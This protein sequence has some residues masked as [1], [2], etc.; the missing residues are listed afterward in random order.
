MNLQLI[1]NQGLDKLRRGLRPLVWGQSL[2]LLTGVGL[3]T[4][5]VTFWVSH[6]QVLHL[7]ICG[8]LMQGFGLLMILSAARVLELVRR[9]DHGAPVTAIQHQLAELRKW[10]VSVEA[11]IN[12]LV[13]SFIWIP[14][15]VMAF[16]ARGLDPWS[17]GLGRWTVLSGVASLGVVAMALWLARRLG[18]GR[19]LE[20]HAAG[21]SV[22]AAKSAL[23][24]IARFE[25]E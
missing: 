23:D 25:R 3:A 11:P 15:I 9:I 1:R 7:L 5:A 24:E 17:A 4:W 19:N 21:S 6:T 20:N 8:L 2:Q 13:G 22:L 14:A 16:A 12:A 18:Y 10:R